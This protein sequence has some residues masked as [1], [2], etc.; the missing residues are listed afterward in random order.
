MVKPESADI[1]QQNLGNVKVIKLEEPI[2]SSSSVTSCPSQ[3]QSVT[4]TLLNAP[5][6]QLKRKHEEESFKGFDDYSKKEKS[7][8]ELLEQFLHQVTEKETKE[9]DYKKRK[10]KRDRMKLKNLQKMVSK[11]ET[12]SKT[13]E[14]I[15][16]KQESVL[17]TINQSKSKNS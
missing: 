13:Q 2:E 10:E 5:S 9:H 6:S 16:R 8:E 7:R 1:Q 4:S 15:L 12:I 3:L 14:E 17:G 11:L